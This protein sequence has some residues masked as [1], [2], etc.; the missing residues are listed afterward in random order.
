MNIVFRA[1]M[2]LLLASLY[3]AGVWISGAQLERGEQS[4]FIFIGFLFS[5]VAGIT[6]PH[7][8]K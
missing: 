6:F 3:C 8:D 5:V 7:A 2:G 4:V 1:V